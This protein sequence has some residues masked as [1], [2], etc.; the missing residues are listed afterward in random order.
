MTDDIESESYLDNWYFGMFA[1]EFGFL[2]LLALLSFELALSLYLAEF[3]CPV[4]D[5]Y[6]SEPKSLF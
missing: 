1:T 2:L 3:S 6:S 5:A 4:I